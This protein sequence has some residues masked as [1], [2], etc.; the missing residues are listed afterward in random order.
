MASLMITEAEAEAKFAKTP[1]IAKSLDAKKAFDVVN[2]SKL[3]A[4]LHSTNITP[5]RWAIIDNLYVESTEC[6]R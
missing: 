3:K 2:H 4:N 1:L 6:I 5:T